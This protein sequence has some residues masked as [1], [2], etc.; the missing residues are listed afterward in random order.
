MTWM[1]CSAVCCVIGLA[2]GNAV[3][4]AVV[5]GGHPHEG[6]AFAIGAAFVAGAIAYRSRPTLRLAAQTA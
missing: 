3:A 1:T 2:L 4:G 5:S 6:Y